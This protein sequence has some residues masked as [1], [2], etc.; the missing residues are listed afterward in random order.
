MPSVVNDVSY[1][2][3]GRAENGCERPIHR[4]GKGEK[5]RV[6]KDGDGQNA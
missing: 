4:L 1:D 6:P 3:N 5:E 2:S